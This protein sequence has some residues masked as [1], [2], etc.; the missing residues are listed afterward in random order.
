[1]ELPQPS[2][3]HRP[4]CG[5]CTDGSGMVVEGGAGDCS[6]TGCAQPGGRKSH[7][8][9]GPAR[10]KLELAVPRRHV[11][12]FNVRMAAK[13]DGDFEAFGCIDGY[14]RK[15]TGKR[16]EASCGVS[17][18]D[19]HLR[20]SK[21]KI[22]SPGVCCPLWPYLGQNPNRNTLKRNEPRNDCSAA[23]QSESYFHFDPHRTRPR[24]SGD[25]SGS[26]EHRFG[27]RFSLAIFF[28]NE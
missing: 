6:I 26:R 13:V 10:W 24:A 15:K 25:H 3:R 8:R 2:A 21:N 5:A 12:A 14:G 11:V 4:R 22:H 23:R 28:V 17:I 7:E 1:M 18:L 27:Y 20:P 9:A 16:I 19:R